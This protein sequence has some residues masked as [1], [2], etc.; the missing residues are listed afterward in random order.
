MKQMFTTEDNNSPIE[1]AVILRLTPGEMLKITK[2]VNPRLTGALAQ[3]R[4]IKHG[5]PSP[6]KTHHG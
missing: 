2:R 6:L 3:L 4:L 1:A 5:D